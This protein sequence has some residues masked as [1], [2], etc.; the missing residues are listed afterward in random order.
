MPGVPEE[1]GKD[2]LDR[3]AEP[4]RIKALVLESLTY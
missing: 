4:P 3:A 1:L 2:V